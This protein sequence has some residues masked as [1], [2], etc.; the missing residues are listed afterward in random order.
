VTRSLRA[1]VF[2]LWNTIAKWPHAEWAE[3]QPRVA[4]RL[5]LSPEEFSERWYGEL[6]HMRETGPIS[7]VLEQFDLSPEAAE[8]VL[9]LRG[10]V[11]RQGLVPVPG[12]AE[13]IAALRERGLKTGL[14]TVCSED[15]PRLW[16][17]TDFHG[18]FDAE[19]FSASVGLRKPDPRIYRLAL[20]ELGV[21]PA[22]AMFVGDGANDELEGARRVGME[23]ILIHRPGEDPPWAEAKAWQGPRVTS[24]PA[25]LELV[26]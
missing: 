5:G 12:A 26:D 3:I 6:A 16:A 17:E 1:V 14:I 21:E 7:A 18:L 24:I 2:D 25:V 9:E 10:A 19:V 4:E 11:T 8:D 13:T 22:E 23:A 15:V 20:D